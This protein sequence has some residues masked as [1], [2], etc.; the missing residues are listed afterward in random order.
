[1]AASDACTSFKVSNVAQTNATD[2]NIA[3]DYGYNCY[4]QSVKE[5]NNHHKITELALVR[6][7]A[8]VVNPAVIS[9]YDG[10]TG[11]FV[12]HWIGGADKVYLV[13]KTVK[14]ALV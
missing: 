1:M 9:D 14:V 3:V 2:Q 8:H 4:L 10:T 11:E 5:S 7:P 6:S 13:W 12:Y